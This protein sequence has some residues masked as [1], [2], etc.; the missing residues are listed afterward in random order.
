MRKIIPA[1]FALLLISACGRVPPTSEVV[2]GYSSSGQIESVQLDSS[3]AAD[4]YLQL[5]SKFTVL[6]AGSSDYLDGQ[7]NLVS[8]PPRNYWAVLNQVRYRYSIQKTRYEQV[9]WLE[10]QI[11]NPAEGTAETIRFSYP[12]K[13]RCGT[14]HY[15]FSSASFRS[16]PSETTI[17]NRFNWLLGIMGQIDNASVRVDG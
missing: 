8:M 4:Y 7:A 5:D 3:V 12:A 1:L 10:F 16:L 11:V 17:I 9:S 15:S 14:L 2:K 13:A 6:S